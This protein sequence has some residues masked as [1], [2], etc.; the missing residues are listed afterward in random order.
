[1]FRV[2]ESLARIPVFYFFS[3]EKDMAAA[4]NL[5]E[6]SDSKVKT[7][8][9][10]VFATSDPRIDAKF[11]TRAQNIVKST[12]AAIANAVKLPGGVSPKV[13]YTPVLVKGEQTA[14]I[15]A[16]Q[17]LEAGADVLVCVPD[18][19]CFPQ[20]TLISFLAH[21]PKDIPV[22]ITCGNSATLPGVV[23]AQAVVG[24]LAQS[25]R[26]VHNI[27]GSWPDDGMDPKMTK[28]THDALV[29]WCQAALA[30]TGLKGRRVLV[31]GHDSMG[32]EWRPRS[33]TSSP[34]A[35]PSASKSPAST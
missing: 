3:Q 7:P 33:R 17:L 27:V 29:D 6:S 30:H 12:A 22:N 13:V 2:S 10:G 32:M 8:V 1:M 5:G 9:I 23:F 24:A 31:F 21:F 14:D 18:A 25:G 28:S 20:P 16:R 4:K 35:A 11:W 15:A 19:W 34:P 26:L